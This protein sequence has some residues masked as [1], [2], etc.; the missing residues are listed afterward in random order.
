MPRRQHDDRDQERGQRPGERDRQLVRG[1][2]RLDGQR[3]QP[4]DEAQHDR[5]VGDAPTSPDERVRELV[6]ES[7]RARNSAAHARADHPLERHGQLRGEERPP[8]RR[9]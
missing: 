4:A 3:G 5:V 9:R 7:P 1:L 8:A 6:G 2:G